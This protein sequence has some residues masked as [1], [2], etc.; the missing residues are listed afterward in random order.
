MVAASPAT[1]NNIRDCLKSGIVQ[2]FA[3]GEPEGEAAQSSVCSG[4]TVFQN[5]VLTRKV[6]LFCN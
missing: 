2:S 6:I 1:P 3:Q 5:L 4:A